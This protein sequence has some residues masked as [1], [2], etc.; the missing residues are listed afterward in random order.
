MAL[1]PTIP[2]SFVPRQPSATPSRAN[3]RSFASVAFFLATGLFILALVAAGGVFAYDQYLG[4]AIQSRA[5][6]LESFEKAVSPQTV[7]ELVRL[8]DRLLISRDLLNDHVSLLSFFTLLEAATLQSVRFSSL[9]FALTG[10]NAGAAEVELTGVARS[11]NALAAQSRSLAADARVRDSIFGN[12]KVN[13]DG[14]I[15]FTLT[16]TLDRRLVRAYTPSA[17]VPETPAE[18]VPGTV[19]EAPAETPSP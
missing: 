7:E 3:G 19:P 16:A 11:F 6:D 10:E 12:I 5:S 18:I 13:Q 9:S 2:T 14:T 15:G 17:A 8:K 4:S 1:P